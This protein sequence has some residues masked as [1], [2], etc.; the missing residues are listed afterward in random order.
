MDDI[1][2]V[3]IA[4]SLVGFVLL[5][6]ALVAL[7][8]K[9]PKKL[10]VVCKFKDDS[11]KNLKSIVEIDVENIGKK[12]MKMLAPYVKFSHAT[13]SKLFQVKPEMVNTRF[14]RI[15]KIG[16]KL[17]CEVDLS[18]YTSSLESIS[19]NPTHV[20]IFLEDTAGLR[21]YSQNLEFSN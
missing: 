7:L 19:F 16:D 8:Y 14:P 13:H 11:I 17:N 15:I 4:L 18:Q 5:V 10:K 20:K 12:R 9:P 21:F 2:G 1:S 6:V 3:T